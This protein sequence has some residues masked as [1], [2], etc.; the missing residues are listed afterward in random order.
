M[1]EREAANKVEKGA[2]RYR[3]RIHRESK[4]AD[5]HKNLP[6]KFS[7]PK[8]SKPSNTHYECEECSRDFWVNEDTVIV[9]CGHCK[10]MNR[11][12]KMDKKD[13]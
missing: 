6:Y 12:K 7:K 11:V 2:R 8:K 13:T 10:H 3:E 9:I 4:F 1:S 5:D